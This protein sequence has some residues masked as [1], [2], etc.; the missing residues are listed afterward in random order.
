MSISPFTIYLWQLC[1]DLKSTISGFAPFL[2]VV[3]LAFGVAAAVYFAIAS[4]RAGEKRSYPSLNREMDVEAE[5]AKFKAYSKF[6]GKWATVSG[7]VAAIFAILGALVP[8]SK[9]IAMMVVIPAIA[10]SK[11]IQQDLPDIYNAAVE[12]LKSSLK[13][14]GK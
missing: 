8:T 7:T 5:E 1:D 4:T 12:A 2:L 3:A 10:N 11:V 6:A 9:T 13:P 14:A